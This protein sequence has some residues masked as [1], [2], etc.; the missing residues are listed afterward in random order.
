MNIKDYEN[1][2][3]EFGVSEPDDFA[4]ENGSG[5]YYG[6]IV[7]IDAKSATIHL[8]KHLSYRGSGFMSVIARPR[9]AGETFL[10]WNTTKTLLVNLVVNIPTVTH[11]I[12]GI[13]LKK[14]KENCK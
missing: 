9:Y 8:K 11:L 3:V 1:M 5:P 7:Q 2:V 12:G 6:T 13:R 10:A 14:P 4:A